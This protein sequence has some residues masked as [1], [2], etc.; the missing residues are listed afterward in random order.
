M[1]RS[2]IHFSRYG[3]IMGYSRPPKTLDPTPNDPYRKTVPG[4]LCWIDLCSGTAAFN[5]V[6]CAHGKFVVSQDIDVDL[7]KTT[8]YGKL[9]H[10]YMDTDIFNDE[11]W[12]PCTIW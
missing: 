10:C 7:D 1:D 4:P 8:L 6:L 9:A 11:S 5:A 2:F 3:P 12:A